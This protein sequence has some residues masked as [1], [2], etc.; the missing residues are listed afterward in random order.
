MARQ[1][2]FRAEYQRRLARAQAKGFSRSQARGH[3]RA[4]EPPLRARKPVESDDR[5]EAALKALRRTGTQSSAAKEAGVS[6][7]RLRR[8]LRENV[9]A[10]RQGRRWRIT[11]RRPRQ[12]RVLSDGQAKMLTVNGFDEASVIGSHLAAVQRFLET[13]DMAELEPFVRRSVTDAAGKTHV[14][15]TDPNSLYRL[16][17]AG[18]EGFEQVYR[19][20]N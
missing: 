7:E 16:A 17:A 2:D 6:P 20:I 3:A 11:D 15:E 5:L 8:F 1:R 4:G 18:S 9:L 10:E 19:L 12:M 13:N 14:L